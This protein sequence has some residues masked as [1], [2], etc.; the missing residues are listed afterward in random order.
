[1]MVSRKRIPL[2]MTL[3]KTES[4]VPFVYDSDLISQRKFMAHKLHELHGLR[5]PPVNSVINNS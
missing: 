5:Q 1:M 3:N 4:A 2:E